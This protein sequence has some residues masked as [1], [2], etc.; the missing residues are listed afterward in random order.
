[1]IKIIK[2]NSQHS[3]VIIKKLYLIILLLLPLFTGGC[4]K[5]SLSEKKRVIIGISSDINS[6]NPLFAFSV[7]EGVITEQMYLSLINFTWN[8]EEG[9]LKAEPMLAKEWRWEK[10]LSSVTFELRDDVYWSDGRKFFAGDVVFSFDVYSDPEVQSRLYGTFEDFYTDEENHINIEKTFEVIDSFNIKINFRSESTPTLFEIVFSLIPQH[11]FENVKRKDIAS[12]EKN[13]RPVTN[14]PFKFSGW[15]KNQ[16]ITLTTDKNSFLYNPE[17]IDEIVF[18]VV[19]D[20]NSRITQLKRSEIDLTELVKTEDV[21][22]LQKFDHLKIIPQ[23]GREYDYIAWSNID[24]KIYNKTGKIVPHKLF[25]SANVRRALTY[26]VN[27]K[28]IMEDYMLGFGQLMIGPVS[29]IFKEAVN[30]DL[31][32]YEYSINKAKDLLGKEGWIDKNKDGI[33]EKGNLDFKFTLYISSGNPRRSYAATIIKNNLKQVG[34]DI[35]IETIE[36]GVIIDN[37][38]NKTMEAWMFGWYVTIPLD[39]K[40]LWYSDLKKTP[41]NFSSYRSEKADKILDEI[42]KETNSKKLNELY[43]QFQ[44]I[45]YEDQPVTFLYWVDNIVVYN[46]RIKNIEINPLGAVHHCWTWT[47]SE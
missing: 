18:K 11:I 42:S 34:I 32:P 23:R 28:E 6:I 47:V 20:Y 36:P 2:N 15:G 24:Q 10:D 43:K 39:L 35:T 25:G 26:A 4:E 14:G 9:D 44:K 8:D 46:S 41:Y 7:D 17:M 29:P 37:M 30:R 38:Y 22:E 16:S 13:S 40:F 27:R 19:P 12:S 33:L 31:E 45:I 21:S 3:L 5:N 1:M